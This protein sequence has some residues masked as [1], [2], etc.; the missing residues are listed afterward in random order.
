[1]ENAVWPDAADLI[2]VMQGLLRVQYTYML[3]T[4]EVVKGKL[5]NRETLARLSI[6]DTLFIAKSR[7]SGESPQ[8]SDLYVEYAQAIEW[9]EAALM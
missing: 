7:L 2:G 6:E 5:R 3:T 9:A 1:M 4:S 8:R